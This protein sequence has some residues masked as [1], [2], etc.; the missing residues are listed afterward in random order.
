LETNKKPASG[1]AAHKIPDEL[2]FTSHGMRSESHTF[3]SLGKMFAEIYPNN[4]VEWRAIGAWKHTTKLS[5]EL[6][7]VHEAYSRH[8]SAK[9]PIEAVKEEIADLFAWLISAWALAGITETT[10]DAF[11]QYFISGCPVCGK[12]KKCECNKFLGKRTNL[13][14]PKAIEELRKLFVSFAKSAGGSAE[15]IEEVSASLVAAEKTQNE[16]IART[17]VL[18]TR[19]KIE[20]LEEGLAR[21]AKGAKD[22][23]TLV[24]S[25]KSILNALGYF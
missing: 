12:E 22:T 25:I 15:E 2:F 11:I 1:I 24:N 20:K 21:G 10:D 19:A 9:K 6:A 3:D 23:S 8:V 16:P 4:N 14:D 17:A 18:E 13:V 7:E 5:E